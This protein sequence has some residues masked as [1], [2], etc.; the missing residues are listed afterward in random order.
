MYIKGFKD[1]LLHENI[2]GI[3]CR[4][5]PCLPFCET[6]TFAVEMLT[7]F[8]PISIEEPVADLDP[9]DICDIVSTEEPIEC[10]KLIFKKTSEE[11]TEILDFGCFE[12]VPIEML[13]NYGA[14]NVIKHPIEE[15]LESYHVV[16]EAQKKFYGMFGDSKQKIGIGTLDQI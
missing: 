16:M 1:R 8:T 9:Y 14:M 7:V 6:V 4:L 3:A 11:S 5:H 13:T 2:L 15:N 12:K 10:L